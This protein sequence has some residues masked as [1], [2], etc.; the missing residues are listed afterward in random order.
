MTKKKGSIRQ[1]QN[2]R[3]FGEE[4]IIQY[5]HKFR[6]IRIRDIREAGLHPETLRRMQ[7]KGLVVRISRGLYMRA[8]QS[9]SQHQSLIEVASRI[10]GGVACLITALRFHEIGT[11][12]PRDV[13]IAVSRTTRVPRVAHPR[14]LIFRFSGRALTAGIETH[15]LHGIEVKVYSAA[16]TVADCFKYR[17]R[18]GTNIAVEALKDALRQRKCTMDDL[19]RYARICRVS[20]IMQPYLEAVA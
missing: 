1:S 8:G 17:R 9:P 7:K 2:H 15:R 20:R 13:W 4:A 5:L 12:A 6:I 11:Q 3:G 16:K 18:I 19:W 14:I 10:P